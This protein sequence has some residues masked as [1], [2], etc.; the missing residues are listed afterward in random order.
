MKK[1]LVAMAMTASLAGAK[2]MTGRLGLGSSTTLGGVTGLAVQYQIA[3]TFTVEPVFSMSMNDGD[4]D[5]GLGLSGFLN[6]ADMDNANLLIGATLNMTSSANPAVED[7]PMG[8]SISIPIRPV[9]FFNDRIAAHVS[10]GLNINFMQPG[11]DAPGADHESVTIIDLNGH[12]FGNA[13]V[14][15]YF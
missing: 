10:T 7:H 9:V 3:K 8:M 5:W 12:L 1:F 4:L 14:T 13:G 6:L 15:F 2:D 11:N